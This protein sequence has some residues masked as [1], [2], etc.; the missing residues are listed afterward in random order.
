MANEFIARKGL[1]ALEDSQITGSLDVSGSLTI[2]SS[3]STLFNVVGSQGQLFSITDSLS[4]SLFAVS[5]ISGLPILE[6]FSDDTVKIG[7]FNNEAIV[8]SGSN[9][10]ITGSFTGSFTGDGSNLTGISSDPFPYTG[11]AVITGSN[12]LAGNYALKVTNTSGAD[13]LNV[14]NDGNIGIGTSNPSSMLEVGTSTNPGKI[15]IKGKSNNGVGTDADCPTLIL[16]GTWH[17]VAKLTIGVGL[18]NNAYSAVFNAGNS[19]KFQVA[20]SDSFTLGGGMT[21]PLTLSSNLL[22]L[23]G[24]I[25]GTGITLRLAENIQTF[26]HTAFVYDWLEWTGF[27]SDQGYTFHTYSHK[28]L[29]ALNGSTGRVGIGTSSPTAMLHVTG[30]IYTETNITASGHI[31]ASTYYGD[32]SNL[33]N[34]PGGDPFPYTGS[35]IISGSLVLT[36]SFNAQLPTSS[37]DTYFVTYNT[38]SYGLE[39]RQVATLINPK[40]EYTDVTSSINSGTSITLPNGL[41]YISSSVYE[42]LEVFVNGLRLRYNMDFIPTS[43]TAIQTQVSFPSG[44][45]LTFKSLKS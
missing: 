5:D 6:V 1:I 45:E 10:T 25:I 27:A 8:V 12:S 43:T 7:S 29:L 32:G 19:Y 15:E 23:G 33:T 24:G 41:S 26:N 39:A 35:A 37:T 40:V 22:N 16:D 9:A 42:Y 34:L 18:S 3:G 14:E 2:D 20:G 11:D 28:N 36:G 38:A 21:A 13:I 31:S 4:G 44:S 17:S 30:A